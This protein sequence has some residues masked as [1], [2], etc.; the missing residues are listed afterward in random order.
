[1]NLQIETLTEFIRFIEENYKDQ[2]D[3]LFRGQPG[4]WPLIPSIARERLTDEILNAERL[5]LEEFQR[6]SLPFLTITPVTVWDW[7]ALAQHHGLPTRLLDWSINPLASLWFAVNKP[8]QFGQNGVVYIFQPGAEDFPSEVDKN[9][10]EC[11]KHFV[12]RPKDIT[13]R[14]TAQLAYFT[15]HKSWNKNPLFESLEES[16]ELEKKLTKIII[17]VNR[18]A[19]FRFHLNRFGMNGA[20]IFPG[21]DGICSR[22][23]WTYCYLEDEGER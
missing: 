15:V 19:H 11:K 3:V 7:L 5:M 23:K 8:V 17:P 6:H 10:I 18:F 9:S 16:V 12:F 1:M 2:S 13:E 20:S 22:I 14:I 4:D 21:L